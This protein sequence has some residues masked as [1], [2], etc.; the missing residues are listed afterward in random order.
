MA[1]ESE[2]L[3]TL[4]IKTLTK[5]SVWDIQENDVFRLWEGAEKDAEVRENVRHYQDI[6]RSAFMIE[7][8]KDDSKVLRQKYEKQIKKLERN[9]PPAE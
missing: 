5:S 6:L 8:L 3:K 2:E 9:E 1:K 4:T 7:E